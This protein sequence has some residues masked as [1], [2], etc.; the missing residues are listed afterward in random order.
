MDITTMTA[1]IAAFATRA[2]K[3]DTRANTMRTIITQ[4]RNELNIVNDLIASETTKVSDLED[5]VAALELT[6][7][8][9]NTLRNSIDTVALQLQE[10]DA[11]IVEAI[12]ETGGVDPLPTDEPPVTATPS[13]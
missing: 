9:T 3:Q 5:R 1:E 10:I 12:R 7:Y 13:F 4:H 6:D 2:T 11:A 8:S